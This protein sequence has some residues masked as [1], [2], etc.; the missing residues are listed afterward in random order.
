MLSVDFPFPVDLVVERQLLNSLLIAWSHPPSHPLPPAF[1]VQSYSIYLDGLL[2]ATVKAKD[3]TKALLEKV[4]LSRVWSIHQLYY[5][6][7]FLSVQYNIYNI[8][9]ITVF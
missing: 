7:S 3:R 2:K 6:R 1:P 4:D 8:Y 5:D 9:N